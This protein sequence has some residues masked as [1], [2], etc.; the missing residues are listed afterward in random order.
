[1]QLSS[2]TLSRV[3]KGTAGAFAVAALAIVGVT[4]AQASPVTGLEATA[5]ATVIKTDVTAG[6]GY[7]DMAAAH[8]RWDATPADA[9]SAAHWR[10]GGALPKVANGA[11]PGFWDGNP[12]YKLFSLAE[13]IKQQR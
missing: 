10:W 11:G 9:R 6:Y 8:W 4:S 2:T 7:N 12:F 3:G 13:L 5:P 1:M